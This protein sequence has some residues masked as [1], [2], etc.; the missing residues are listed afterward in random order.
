[1]NGRFLPALS[2]VI[3]V[4]GVTNPRIAA[5][6]PLPAEPPAPSS[7]VPVSPPV[8]PTPTEAYPAAIQTLLDRG[9]RLAGRGMVGDLPFWTIETPAGQ[10]TYVTSPRGLV[11]Q[12]QLYDS[13]GLLKLDTAAAVP[14][15]A[16][17]A[18]QRREGLQPLLGETNTVLPPTAGL[19]DGSLPAPAS[20][21]DDSLAAVETL[22]RGQTGPEAVWADLGQ[23]T[24]IEEGAR[25]APLVYAF[26]D[27]YCP[28][29]HQQWRLLRQ[30]IADGTLRVRWVPVVV[31]EASKRQL[32]RVLGLLPPTD[33]EGLARW[34][35]RHTGES[36]TD[37]QAKLAL[38]RN[39]ALFGRL[40]ANQVPALLY[41]A[42]DGRVILRAGLS[43]LTPATTAR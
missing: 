34:M 38:V 3:L 40:Q 16:D 17:P 19:A 26:I 23:A 27:P 6:D 18:R 43:P 36:R 39:Q 35:T 31:L 24:V 22:A 11:I 37:A 13:G 10:Q 20:A 42:A 4:A 32:P 5:P 29:C 7:G 8:A 1:M 2:L 15:I 14:V 30:P 41:R 12:G 28:Y 25:T 33:A 21:L 9:G